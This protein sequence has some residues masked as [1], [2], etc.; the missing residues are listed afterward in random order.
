MTTQSGT[1][2]F[3]GSGYDYFRAENLNAN[4]FQSNYSKLPLAEMKQHNPGF[5]V[6]VR[7]TSLA[8]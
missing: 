4:S 5:T 7:C 2:A 6:A 8:L 3:H 1:N